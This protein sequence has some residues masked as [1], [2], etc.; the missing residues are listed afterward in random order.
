MSLTCRQIIDFLDDYV[1]GSQPEDVRAAFEAHLAAC[2]ECEDYLA[3]YRDTIRLSRSLCADDADPPGLPATL[4][5]AILDARR[6]T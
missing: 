4:R 2:P 6:G 5:A 3:T 1:D